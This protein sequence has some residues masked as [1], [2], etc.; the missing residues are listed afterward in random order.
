MLALLVIAVAFH[1]CEGFLGNCKPCSYNTY[2]DGVLINSQDDAVY[3]D[4][5]LL[6]IE[7]TTPIVDGNLEYKWFCH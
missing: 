2:E 7:A 4:N 1:S 5:E 6:T 3:C